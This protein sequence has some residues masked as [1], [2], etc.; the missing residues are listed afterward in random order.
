[1]ADF[2]GPNDAVV[3]TCALTGV[4]TNPAQHPVPVTPKE[5]AQAA[6]DAANAGAA[7]VHVHLRDQRPNLGHLPS[8]EPDVAESIVTAIREACP[9]LVINLT[10]GI[11][12]SDVSGP[13]ACLER[14]RPEMAALNAG[15]LNYLKL[16]SNHSWAWPPLLFDN[17][18]AKIEAMAKAM[19]RLG[20]VPEC[21]CFDTGIVRSVGLLEQAGVLP[22]P[23]NISLVMG[24][25]SGMPAKAEW[26]PLLVEEMPAGARWQVIGIGREEV[27]ALHRRCAE[28]GGHLRSGVEDTFYLPSGEKTSG[29]GP[30]VEALAVIAREVGR[31]IA[32]PEQA[33]RSLG[34]R[35]RQ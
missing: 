32:S 24:V 10:T 8:W 12:G 11:M 7:I 17:P 31:P 35:D 30:L 27:W 1:M 9:E 26:L 21:E 3:L 33:R 16:R 29:N 2:Q 4:L 34:I 13:I 20:V 14:V 23:P 5:M 22:S 15:S 18:V 19:A 25:A 6:L 28:L